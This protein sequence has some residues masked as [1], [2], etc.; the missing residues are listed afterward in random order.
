VI[1]LVDCRDDKTVFGKIDLVDGARVLAEPPISG[2]RQFECMQQDHTVDT[3]MSDQHDR[4]VRMPVDN[5]AER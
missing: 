5:F 4:I 3:N 1:A 2:E